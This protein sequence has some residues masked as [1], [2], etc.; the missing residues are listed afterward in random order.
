[1]HIRSFLN[2]FK[3]AKSVQ[4]AVSED[5]DNASAEARRVHPVK[6]SELTALFQT[7][8]EEKRDDLPAGRK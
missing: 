6:K 3:A 2:R 4:G 5:M 7:V 1:M 8:L